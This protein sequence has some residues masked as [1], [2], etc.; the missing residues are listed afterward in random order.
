MIVGRLWRAAAM[1]VA[2]MFLSHLEAS[3]RV[4]DILHTADVPWDGDV[5]IVV[6]R[7]EPQSA[8]SPARRI[9]PYFGDL[10]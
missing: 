5:G 8:E 7:L 1:T 10:E 2:G 4:F 6:L 3:Q 9:Y